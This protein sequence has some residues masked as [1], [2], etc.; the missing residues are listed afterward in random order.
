[1]NIFELAAK[2]SLDDKGFKKGVETA[3]KSSEDLR[4][5]VM[6]LAQTYKAQGMSMSDALKKAHA[7]ID[8]SQYET[9][10]ESEKQSNKFS[11]NWKNVFSGI[12]KAAQVTGKV[13]ATSFKA[14]VFTAELGG[15]A[16][17]ALL[18]VG[19]KA[20]N[21]FETAGR[22]AIDAGGK[23]QTLGET[24]A[25]VTAGISAAIAA[26]TAGLV[27]LSTDQFAEYEQLVGGVE[28][29]FKD[30]AAVVQTYANYAYKTAG[31]SANEYMSTVTSFSASLLQSLGGDTKAA[32]EYANQALVDM[33]D[34]ANKMGTD[35]SLIQNA[36]QG[37][38][39]QNYTMLDNLKL[40]YGG[41]KTEMERLVADAA[42]LDDSI[43]ASSLSFGNIVK[44]IHAV[45][46]EMG[47]TGTTAKEAATTIQ[48]AANMTKASWK[49]LLTALAKGNRN[50]GK[51]L[52]ALID[53]AGIYIDNLVP[54][55]KNVLGSIY[56][57]IDT[58][59]VEGGN[60]LVKLLGNADAALP[61]VLGKVQHLVKKTV[62]FIG[63]KKDDIKAA[64]T[65]MFDGLLS[66]FTETVD[67]VLPLIGDFLP[68]V[69]TK[70]FTL[71]SSLFGV[72]MDIVGTVAESIGNNS[73]LIADSFFGSVESIS[74]SISRNSGKL[75]D[76]GLKLF[77]AFL[78][79]F[80]KRGPDII[81]GFAGL[82]SDLAKKITSSGTVKKLA[83]AAKTLFGSLT[84]SFS[85]VVDDLMP[86]VS[87]LVP[88][89]AEGILTKYDVLLNT[90]L[91]VIMA[92]AEGL[93]NNAGELADKA[94]GVITKFVEKITSP[95]VLGKLVPAAIKILG[96]LADEFANNIDKLLTG[97]EKIIGYIVDELKKEDNLKNLTNSA[98]TIIS[99]L[100]SFIISNL[101]SAA[102]AALDLAGAAFEIIS[103]VITS[104]SDEDS[105]TEIKNG[106][107][108]FVKN[109]AEKIKNIDFNQIE[110]VLEAALEVVGALL[111]GM[112][113]DEAL[114]DMALAAGSVVTKLF[115][116]IIDEVREFFIE[117]GEFQ[118]KAINDMFSKEYWEDLLRDLDAKMKEFERQ[119]KERE[120]ERIKEKEKNGSHR[121]GL[122][123]VPYDGYIA[124]LH[125]GERVLTRGEARDYK[126][127]GS[128]LVVNVTVNGARYSDEESLAEAVAEKIQ[129]KI[130]RERAVYA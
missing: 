10:K 77:D 46:T 98:S 83:T 78:D 16:G 123:Y 112:L 128:G 89:I 84:S 14:A 66:G 37:F 79:G 2:I 76:G 12:G 50:Y 36:Y 129:E 55:V 44:A 31:L 56:N 90:G 29:L 34:N 21:A 106:A 114:E 28:T 127:G 80:I 25:K 6:K 121:N 118:T 35:M 41:T 42:K 59:L 47:I 19:E 4:K 64:A 68:T 58:R 115:Q 107:T 101:G 39:K 57:I 11:L 5:D 124:E 105:L 51:E 130:E 65:S 33:S 120:W 48:G 99:K 69:I 70:F 85:L 49:N 7:T 71:K 74:A 30:S 119:R 72:G 32:A 9:T 92:I 93:A 103:N 54:R 100:A 91:D 96:K 116:Y 110:E 122:S 97:V 18:S 109:L 61:T 111:G 43:D 67:N 94:V 102:S 1:M 13:V 20:V 125:E 117:F 26:G 86:L 24:A 40:G 113:S 45:Q 22:A 108:D 75:T 53:S 126:A 87:E 63:S 62:D 82:I 15:K 17:G 104:L 38:A 27:K 73:D 95:E 3:K 88:I 52:S 81:T 60:F 8:K 23:V